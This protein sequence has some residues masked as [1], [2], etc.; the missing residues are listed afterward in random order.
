MTEGHED[1]DGKCSYYSECDLCGKRYYSY[2]MLCMKVVDGK[3]YCPECA[4]RH[5]GFHRGKRTDNVYAPRSMYR[6]AHTFHSMYEDKPHFV[7]TLERIANEVPWAT[8]EI[9]AKH[10]EKDPMLFNW[11]YG[12]T[13]HI[14]DDHWE[15]Y[16]GDD[17]C[18]VAFVYEPAPEELEKIKKLRRFEK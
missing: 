7:T 8:G 13:G 12:L 6:I 16:I 14:D 10:Y 2:D 11:G 18:E 17:P 3:D 15:I 4:I 5:L 1:V 9:S